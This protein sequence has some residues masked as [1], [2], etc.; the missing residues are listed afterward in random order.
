VFTE[1]GSGYSRQSGSRGNLLYQDQRGILYGFDVN[2][3]SDTSFTAHP[4]RLLFEPLAP[5][6]AVVGS[7]GTLAKLEGDLDF[8]GG[9][10]YAIGSGLGIGQLDIQ[11]KMVYS[12]KFGEL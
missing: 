5:R 10:L 1:Q 11:K 9:H 7:P 6:F 12:H 2:I 8:L 4:T 3:G